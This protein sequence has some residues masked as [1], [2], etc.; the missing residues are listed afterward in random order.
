M[1]KLTDHSI[2]LGLFSQAIQDLRILLTA[3]RQFGAI[4]IGK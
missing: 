2:R 4:S 1:Q 3:P